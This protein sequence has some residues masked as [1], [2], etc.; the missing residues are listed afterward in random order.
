M[1]KAGELMELGGR[2]GNDD[3]TTVIWSDDWDS[4]GDLGEGKPGD[5]VML[6]EDIG[7]GSNKPGDVIDIAAGGM[8]G[9]RVLTN[10]G[11]GR[12]LSVR[13]MQ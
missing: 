11:I 3:D 8:E 2:F 9:V 13:V 1:M 4:A 6:L 10:L 5:I 12:V 7:F